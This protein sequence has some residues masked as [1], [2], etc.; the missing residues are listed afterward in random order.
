MF[1]YDRNRAD[2]VY[3][4]KRQLTDTL[5]DGRRLVIAPDVIGDFTDMAFEDSSF[6]V[7]VF[8]PPHLVSAGEK[9]WIAKKYGTLPKDYIPYLTKGINECMRVLKPNGTLIFKWSDE[10]IPVDKILKA[11][12][13]Q[14]LI[15]DKR[16]KTRW[17]VFFK[18][19]L[20]G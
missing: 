17:L 7:V 8:D 14:P 19:G 2:T 13:Y 12:P 18:E 1:W 15:G 4:D 5:C 16:G 11:I 10:Q 9:S 6:Y 3:M 20:D